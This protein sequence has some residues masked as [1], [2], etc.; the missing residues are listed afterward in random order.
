MGGKSKQR[1]ASGFVAVVEILLFAGAIM[2]AFLRE[3]VLAILL[4][5]VGALLWLADHAG[6]R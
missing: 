5:S 1:P 3:P 6:K 4:V 2:F